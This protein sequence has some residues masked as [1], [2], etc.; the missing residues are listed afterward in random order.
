[1]EEECKEDWISR[2]LTISDESPSPAPKAKRGGKAGR[3]GAL[4]ASFLGCRE[5]KTSQYTQNPKPKYKPGP[6]P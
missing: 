6:K 5:M 4:K 2:L 1:M 3:G